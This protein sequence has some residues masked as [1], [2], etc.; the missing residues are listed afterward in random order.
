[1]ERE[2]DDMNTPEIW[3]E[4]TPLDAE[5]LAVLRSEVSEKAWGFV[6]A[7]GLACERV[8]VESGEEGFEWIVF[9]IGG[10]EFCWSSDDRDEELAIAA[11]IARRSAAF[12]AATLDEETIR[13]AIYDEVQPATT[14]SATEGPADSPGLTPFCSRCGPDA[15]RE[16]GALLCSACLVKE[17]AK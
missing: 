17:I 11:A 9:T 14:L 12:V 7:I 3:H 2:S 6:C 10:E 13:R 8:A 5:G 1:M 15:Y 16:E 4:G